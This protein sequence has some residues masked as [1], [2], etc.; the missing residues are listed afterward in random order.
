MLRAK[1]YA[2]TLL[3]GLMAATGAYADDAAPM[4]DATPRT[5]SHHVY[6]I[7]SLRVTQPWIDVTGTPGGDASAYLVVQNRG[8][9]PDRLTGASVVGAT[10][11]S[12]LPAV[13]M[14]PAGATVVL[15]PGQAHL[16]VHGLNGIT[17]TSPPVDATL[18]FESAGSLHLSFMTDR[19]AALRNDEPVPSE[20]RPVHL[21]Q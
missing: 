9:A 15:Q 12:V 6:L 4:V 17:T 19:A 1:P 14:V 2:I 3:C 21:S 18:R 10:S 7:G 16:V 5:A 11:A 20:D 13:V 8:A